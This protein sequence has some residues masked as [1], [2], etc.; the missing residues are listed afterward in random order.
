MAETVEPE[1]RL[2]RRS[3]AAPIT[4][5]ALPEAASGEAPTSS[6]GPPFHA[7]PE[8]DRADKANDFVERAPVEVSGDATFSPGTFAVTGCQA[9]RR[10]SARIRWPGG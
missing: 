5:A 10:Q 6:R 2:I 1:T 7:A 8:A 4:W 3:D 9:H